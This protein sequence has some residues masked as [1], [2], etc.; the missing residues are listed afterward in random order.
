MTGDGILDAHPFTV[1]YDADAVFELV[2]TV[3]SKQ[4]RTALFNV[5]DKLR[6]LGPRLV[7]PHMKPL[8]SAAGLCEMRP[9]QGRSDWRPIY[10]RVDDRFVVL[11][12]ARHGE[13]EAALARAT[14][15]SGR[16]I[17]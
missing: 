13:F 1:V 3:K 10:I 8:H 9:R 11:T 5:V 2:T 12:I 16:Y 15:R 17:P 6:Q 4:E 14:R 7:P